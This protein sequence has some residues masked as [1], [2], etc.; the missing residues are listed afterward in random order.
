M[1]TPTDADT[2][3]PRP[4][5]SSSA[6]APSPPCD[7]I[8]RNALR[9]TVSAREYAALHKY[10]LSRNRV[11]RRSTPSPAAVEKALHPKDASPSGEYNAKAVRHALRVFAVTWTGMKGYEFVLKKMSKKEC[12]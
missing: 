12:V 10:I 6:S 2:G 4:R 11:L 9:Y 8:T 5:K 3:G 7:A 1:S